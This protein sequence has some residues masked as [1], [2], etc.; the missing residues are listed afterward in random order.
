MA[1]LWDNTLAF[2]IKIIDEQHKMFVE[3]LN[4]LFGVF[5]S[6]GIPAAFKEVLDELDHYSTVHFQTEEKYFDEFDFSGKEEHKQ[7]HREF[8]DKIEAIK[9]DLKQN[10]MGAS[11]ELVDYLEDWLIEHLS[12]KDKKYI[13]C[14]KS[15]GL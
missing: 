12:G 2:N 4:K 11:V 14:F 13:E 9:N 1:I 8:R 3:T 5:K 10:K 6:P 15:H 7:A